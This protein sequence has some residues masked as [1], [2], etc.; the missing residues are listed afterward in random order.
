[1]LA[2]SSYE[3]IVDT[4][5][6]PHVRGFLHRPVAPSGDGLVLTHGA[7]SNSKAP[8]LVALSEAFTAAGVTVLRCNLPYRQSRPYGPP[9]PGDAV[10]DREGL[11]NA[12]TALRK[13]AP[14]RMFLGGHSYGGRQ[15]TMLC[16][17]QPDLVDGLLLLSYPLHPPRKPDQLRV[18]H[19]PKLQTPALFVH[20]TRDPFGSPEEMESAVSLIPVKTRLVRIE[21]AGH[22]LGF[23][24]QLSE[25]KL[26]P[27]VVK[28]FETMFGLG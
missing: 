20:G 19:L 5:F 9:R 1:M 11:K 22:D 16:A 15:S 25:P 14:G 17:D 26:V 21:G 10:H 23:K 2:N 7:G 8:L 6:D 27:N 4:S 3:S 24:G 18:Q 12:V 28:E 13:L